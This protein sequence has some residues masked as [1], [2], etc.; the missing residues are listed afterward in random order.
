MTEITWTLSLEEA[1]A[2][3]NMLGELPSKTCVF[4][5]LI[6]LKEQTDAQAP[7]EQPLA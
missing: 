4:P 3:L 1:S 6:R 2:I 5:L 7:V